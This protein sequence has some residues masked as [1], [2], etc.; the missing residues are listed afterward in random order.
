MAVEGLEE[1]E[2][3][4]WLTLRKWFGTTFTELFRWAA[5]KIREEVCRKNK[6]SG[7]KVTFCQL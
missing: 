2:F 1:E 3:H 4:G 6:K 5:N 7:L